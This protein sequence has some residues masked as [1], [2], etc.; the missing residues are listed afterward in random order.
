MTALELAVAN[1][2]AW[3]LQVAVIGVVAAAVSRLLPVDRPA[4]R[5]AFGQILLLVVVF[6]PS[7]NPGSR[8]RR[9]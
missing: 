3:S 7:F 9:R 1:L 5:L 4:V 2:G 8:C 6:L